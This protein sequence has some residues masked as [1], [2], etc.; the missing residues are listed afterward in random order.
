MTPQ[1]LNLDLRL[2]HSEIHLLLSSL[3]YFTLHVPDVDDLRMFTFPANDEMIEAHGFDV[4]NNLTI[5]YQY[6]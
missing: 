4:D 3:S 2:V 1:S 5:Y 6:V